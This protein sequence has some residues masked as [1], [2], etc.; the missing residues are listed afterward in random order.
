MQQHI[1]QTDAIKK[2]RQHI[3]PP[4]ATMFQK[5]MLSDRLKTKIAATFALMKALALIMAIYM[6]GLSIIPC[7]D[8][9]AKTS[10]QQNKPAQQHEHEDHEDGCSPFCICSCC[11]NIVYISTTSLT[12]IIATQQYFKKPNTKIENTAIA[13]TYLSN[14]WQPPKI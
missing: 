8:A 3:K 9:N 4:I 13:N 1:T 5:Q 7:S 6:L 2:V 10:T 14:I 11:N 12:T